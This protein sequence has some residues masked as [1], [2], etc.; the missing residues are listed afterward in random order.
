MS[1]RIVSYDYDSNSVYHFWV[2]YV[3]ANSTLATT[4]RGRY[5]Y[6]PF[7]R[8]GKGESNRFDWLTGRPKEMQ[9]AGGGAGT[10]TQRLRMEPWHN[11]HKSSRSETQC[12][13]QQAP[14]K[15]SVGFYFSGTRPPGSIT[16]DFCTE[17]PHSRYSTSICWWNEKMN[18]WMMNSSQQAMRRVSPSRFSP[19]LLCRQLQCRKHKFTGLLGVPCFFSLSSSQLSHE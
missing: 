13:P 14:I 2:L 7:Y 4:L 16:M 17:M 1:A 8:T 12:Q 5:Y 10:L 6:Y 18:E 11:A 9:W 15:K 19:D 3:L